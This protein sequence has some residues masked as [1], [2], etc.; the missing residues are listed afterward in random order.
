MYYV[1]DFEPKLIVQEG[2]LAQCRGMEKRCGELLK[3]TNAAES[4]SSDPR[5]KRLVNENNKRQKNQRD[6]T[7]KSFAFDS[8]HNNNNKKNCCCCF[9][10][11]V[12]WLIFNILFGLVGL[13]K[14]CCCFLMT[15]HSLFFPADKQQSRGERDVR[16][17]GRTIPSKK[18]KY[19]PPRVTKINEL[20]HIYIGVEKRES[21]SFFIYRS[22]H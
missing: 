14:G 10:C 1:V 4:L 7:D 17:N 16:A 5:A 3:R 18:R 12:F 13:W 20:L 21:K 15:S 11:F 19:P 2:K 8:K 22:I 6:K 9:V